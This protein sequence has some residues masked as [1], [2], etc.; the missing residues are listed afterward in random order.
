MLALGKGKVK[1][2]FDLTYPFI[3]GDGDMSANVGTL[4]GIADISGDTAIYSSNEF[5]ECR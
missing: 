4:E 3:D 5:G 1:L 2:A